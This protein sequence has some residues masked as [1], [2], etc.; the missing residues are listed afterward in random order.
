[1]LKA[2]EQDLEIVGGEVRVAGAPDIRIGLGRVAHAVAGTPG[3]ALPGEVEPGMEATEYFVI[4]DMAYANGSAVA[5]VEVDVETGAVRLSAYAVVH[6]PGRAI[7][8]GIVTAQL[9][10]GAVQSIGAGLMEQIVYDESVELI[11]HRSAINPL[12]VKGVGESGAIPGAAAIANAIEDAVGHLGA[13]IREVPVTA[14]SLHAL[15]A[16][17]R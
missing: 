6:D 14:S 11:E 7:H 16:G 10:G 5:E 8:P 9:Q 17:A 2:S 1:M 15:L 13:T 12:G 4:E 3:Y